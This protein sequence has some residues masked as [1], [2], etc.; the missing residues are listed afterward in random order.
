[1]AEYRETETTDQT[2]RLS[3]A[4]PNNVTEK[5]KTVRDCLY[6]RIDVSLKGIDRFI[7]GLIA[8]LVVAIFCGIIFK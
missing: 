5:K 7:C 8:L 6:G 4:E 2:N 1:M 3:S